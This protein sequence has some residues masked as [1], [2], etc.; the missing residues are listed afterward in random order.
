[1][2]DATLASGKVDDK[3]L[4]RRLKNCDL[5]I[6]IAGAAAKQESENFPVP[7]SI[8]ELT[9]HLLKGLIIALAPRVRARLLRGRGVRAANGNAENQGCAEVFHGSV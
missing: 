4:A 8:F 7:N 2:R 9:L 5:K 6:V 1:M 3:N